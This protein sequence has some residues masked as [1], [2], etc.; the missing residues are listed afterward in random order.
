MFWR[1]NI[2][3]A[4]VR[5]KLW[6]AKVAAE[7]QPI[8]QTNVTALEQ[9]QP[10]DL[11]PAEISVRLGS[12][13]VPEADIQQF[14]WELLQ[15]PWYMRS[16]IKVHYSP[17]TGAWQIEGRSVD[18][19]SIYASSTYGTQRV[20]GYHILEDCLNLREVKVFDYVEVDGKRKAILNK[21]ET[22]HC[23][24]KTGGDQASVSGLDLGEPGPSGAA[25]NALQ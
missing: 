24:G 10:E 19:G 1:K 2:S 14:V 23:P 7:Q 21:K 9:V 20:S 4:N 5:E 8:Y 15:P 22:A 17:Y 18:S 11:S 3:P 6:E 25:D 13:W 16:R 12:T